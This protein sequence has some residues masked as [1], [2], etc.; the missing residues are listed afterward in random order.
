MAMKARD[1]EHAGKARDLGYSQIQRRGVDALGSRKRF[2]HAHLAL[3]M[4]R[5]SAGFD[6]GEDAHVG[7][8]IWAS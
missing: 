6:Y 3:A 7:P 1:Q 4:T 2:D 8:I 5:L